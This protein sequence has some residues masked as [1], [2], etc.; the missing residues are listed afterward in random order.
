[1]ETLRES[2][3]GHSGGISR[4]AQAQHAH[5]AGFVC[6]LFFLEA[7]VHAI[8]DDLE[9]LILLL[10]SP[11]WWDYRN[12]TESSCNACLDNI[13]PSQIRPFESNSETSFTPQ[14]ADRVWSQLHV[15]IRSRWGHCWM[16]SAH[17]TC[18]GLE[19]N[20]TVKVTQCILVLTFAPSMFMTAVCSQ[21]IICRHVINVKMYFISDKQNRQVPEHQKYLSCI[22]QL[23]LNG[24]IIIC[25]WC[26]KK[27]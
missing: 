27:I 17:C 12:K 26:N 3:T 11:Q 7:W 8:Q 21:Y 22:L 6:V 1:M 10:L 19:V 24:K 18:E 25:I 15:R 13:S 23:V 9:Q 16:G 5:H 14:M 4:A 20:S 2:R